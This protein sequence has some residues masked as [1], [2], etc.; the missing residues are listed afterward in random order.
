MIPK[1]LRMRNFLSHDV[2]EIDFSLFD[3]ALIL[4]TYDNEPDQSNGS[5]KS[6]IFEAI[7]WALFGKSRHKKKNGV[8]KW[9]KPACMVEF[10]FIIDDNIYLVRRSRDKTIND[11]D[12][13]FDVISC[14]RRAWMT[15]GLAWRGCGSHR[16]EPPR[17]LGPG[18]TPDKPRRSEHVVHA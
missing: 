3:V 9:D 5:G 8:V 2:S 18:E 15:D 1:Y 7:T 4:G 11:S 14:A 17:P 16:R 12:V 6:A 10:E 13:G